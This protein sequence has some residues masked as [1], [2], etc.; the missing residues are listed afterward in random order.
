MITTAGVYSQ[1]VHGGKW[2]LISNIT[3]K[4]LS[5]FTF[6]VLA[7]F[8]HPVDYG[9]MGIIF[10]INGV[11]V[12]IASIDFERALLQKQ[13]DLVEEGQL[14]D[15]IWTFNF[16]KSIFLAFVVFL[17]APWCASWFHIPDQVAIIRW[18]AVLM[19]FLGLS[20]SRLFYF[21]KNIDYQKF[22]WRDNISQ[23]MYVVVTFLWI[24]LV[25]QSAWA[26][27]AGQVARY[28]TS[29]L[30]T[31]VLHPHVQFFSF[32]FNSLKKLFGYA[33]WVSVH[34]MIDYTLGMID[35]LYIGRLLDA[36][37][38]GSYI[39]ARDL[40][41]APVSPFFIIFDKLGFAAYAKIQN[42]LEKIQNGFLK[43]FDVMLAV[44]VPIF[45][46]L[47]A[48]G[49]WIVT[50]LLGPAWLGIVVPL[51]ILSL[52][53]IFSSLVVIARPLF[54]A[55]GRPDI[56]VKI[57]VV[58]LVSSILFIYVGAYFWDL[59]GVA[60]A[61]LGAWFFSMLY[62]IMKARPILKL[63]WDKFSGSVFTV[64]GSSAIVSLVALPLY[65]WN[66]LGGDAFFASSAIILV[67]GGLYLFLLYAIGRM[68]KLGP[69]ATF[70]SILA[71]LR[72]RRRI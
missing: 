70:L 60:I 62:T 63:G 46:L 3:Q 17:I 12:T 31:Y 16:F 64:G 15:V 49:G 20:N 53:M 21:T 41:F 34:G 67:L 61:M 23:I 47:L 4:F 1:S 72:L 19:L 38:L 59:S 29:V 44:N 9:V 48:K 2:I 18:S 35:T 52:S 5:L 68:F 26:L 14:L 6:L 24:F 13:T 7:R 66:D 45:L 25:S 65:L 71:E 39:K 55:M 10:I 36:A 22:F 28:G 54:D 32:Q 57:N 58:Q 56:N 30:M 33:K 42:Q 43:T 50:V 11:L 51:K 69:W 8:L 40:S 37:K 27:L